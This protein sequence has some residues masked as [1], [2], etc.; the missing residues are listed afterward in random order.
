MG[1]DV[2]G[3]AYALD[4]LAA[5]LADPDAGVAA[6][7]TALEVTLGPVA[8]VPLDDTV[9]P[10][11]GFALR[12]ALIALYPRAR[13]ELDEYPAIILAPQDSTGRHL[14]DAGP[15]A[16]T[17]AIRRRIRIF[18]LVRGPD[19]EAAGRAR[20][21][22]DLA[23]DEALHRSPRLADDLVLVPEATIG[24]LS[25]VDV[26]ETDGAG[27]AGAYLEVT[28]LHA[29]QVD[30]PPAGTVETVAVTG[31]P[32]PAGGPMPTNDPHPAL[33]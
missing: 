5:R 7:L 23:V 24:S 19:V 10:T 22:L 30:R 3:V 28:V 8:G 6:H 26:D 33:G 16:D 14:T 31:F 2:K 9:P 29:D 18:S 27:V 17:W 11:A 13:L 1:P 32:V 4:L 15:L 20:D 25:D 12:P 21:R